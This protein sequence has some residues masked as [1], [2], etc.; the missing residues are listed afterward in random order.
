[1]PGCVCGHVAP[2]QPARVPSTWLFGPSAGSRC[3]HGAVR[4]ACLFRVR[5]R[6]RLLMLLARQTPAGIFQYHPHQWEALC[7]DMS[8]PCLLVVL[9]KPGVGRV[10]SL[11][12]VPGFPFLNESASPHSNWLLPWEL[13][14]GLPSTFSLSGGSPGSASRSPRGPRL[15][16]SRLDQIISLKRSHFGPCRARL[17][18][19]CSVRTRWPGQHGH[20]VKVRL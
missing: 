13:R 8:A 12:Q 17:S 6:P 3:N 15:A 11:V 16:A 4:P 5:V 9:M 19:I 2:L 20:F 1:M 14:L 18:P 10:G 7:G